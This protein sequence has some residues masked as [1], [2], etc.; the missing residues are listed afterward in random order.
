[1]HMSRIIVGVSLKSMQDCRKSGTGA[2]GEET[3]RKESITQAQSTRC[4]ATPEL[5]V[6]AM[7]YPNWVCLT[8]SRGLPY[9]LA[10][11]SIAGRNARAARLDLTLEFYSPLAIIVNDKCLRTDKLRRRPS[12]YRQ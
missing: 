3:T 2:H 11:K 5:R 9:L 7:K 4:R 10:L 8:K 12:Q 6:P 1:M